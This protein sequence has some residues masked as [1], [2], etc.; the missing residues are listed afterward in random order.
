MLKQDDIIE[1]TIEK[2]INTG[3]CLSHYEGKAVFIDNTVPGDIVK[4]RVLRV[5][6]SFIRAKITEII[7]P[8]KHR[9]KPFC[10]LFNACGGCNLQNVEY[11]FLIKQKENI[12]K[13]TFRNFTNV[14]FKPF[15]K[16]DNLK[17]YRCKVQ[18]AVSETKVSKRLLAGYYKENSHDVVN[19]KFCPI[20]PKI[21]DEIINF[22]RE[23]WKM[24]AYIEK[25]DKGLLKHILVRYSN[26]SKKMILTFVI[27]KDFEWY[28]KIKEE[29]A[30]FS[31]TLIE[32]FPDI[33]GVLVNFNPKKT[34]KITG[35][36]T[37]LVLGDDFVYEKLYSKKCI[38][39]DGSTSKDLSKYTEYTYKI[40]RD[41]FFQ[42][43]PPVASKIF[44]C[45]KS[46]IP[47]NSNIL[48]AY[49]GVGTIGIFLSDKAKK[50]TLVE[51][52]ES[53][54]NDAK[55]NFKL[56]KC[57]NYEVFLGDAKEIFKGFLKPKIN[58]T[59]KGKI[60]EKTFDAA[61]L[62]PP[63]KGSDKEALEII[64][65]LTKS[66]VYVSCNPATL[67]RDAKIL[68]TLG[69]KLKSIQGADMFPFTHHIESVAHFER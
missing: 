7:T 45:V 22:I 54:I 31:N 14:E 65:K 39:E 19:I 67:E 56:N 8:S 34:N 27:N 28:N 2:L 4:A 42:I 63:R 69:F 38:F 10:P 29:I 60:S 16:C 15:L 53:A 30:E 52:C 25:K 37:E 11:D 58:N 40:S 3:S 35:D 32:N 26:F 13:E 24:G 46:L 43:N 55:T 59:N 50:I 9:I 6:K 1:L 66:I 57:S 44:D 20:Q 48:D 62:D 61:I 12:L 51:E 36:K 49:G 64:S 47:D 17:E 33:I 68:E 41:S 18:N 21:I 23:N 5:N